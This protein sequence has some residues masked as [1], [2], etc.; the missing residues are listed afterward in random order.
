MDLKYALT[1]LIVGLLVGMT[2]MGGG[3][4]MTPLLI[5]FFK[6]KASVAVGS[7]LAYSAV[8]KVFGSFVHKTAGTVDMPLVWRL[9]MGSIPGSLI[10]AFSVAALERRYGSAAEHWLTRAI[11][12]MLV[13]VA[14]SL[15]I[16]SF[17]FMRELIPMPKVAM[18]RRKSLNLAVPIGFVLGV[19]VGLTS[20][21]SGAFFAV[22]FM[23]IFGL[24]SKAMVG[25]DIFQAMLLTAA[26]AGAHMWAGDVNYKLVGTLLIGAIPGIIIG[27]KLCAITPYRI[28][29]P[30]LAT[31][32]LL[33]GLKI[34]TG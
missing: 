28:L 12:V 33:S 1:G 30:T 16:R 29:R 2:G 32:L 3:S 25:T 7:D 31:V 22:A 8:M 26:A 17:K 14:V 13:L 34:L 24:R 27:S 21:G 23:L 5:I 11:G 4:L 9:C 15:L 10:G 18:E 6:F 19:L 20:V